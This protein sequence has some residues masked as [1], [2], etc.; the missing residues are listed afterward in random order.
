MEEKLIKRDYLFHQYNPVENS[1][2][3][4]APITWRGIVQHLTD[5]RQVDIAT[6]GNA[7]VADDPNTGNIDE[8]KQALADGT[9]VLMPQFTVNGR[10]IGNSVLIYGLSALLRLNVIRAIASDATTPFFKD[11][12]KFKYGFYTWRKITA[13]GYLDNNDTPRCTQLIQWKPFG[14]S[15]QLD[16][17]LAG[18]N[19]NGQILATQNLNMLLNSEKVRCLAKGECVIPISSLVGADNV[20]TKRIYKELSTPIEIMYEPLSQDGSHIL[21]QKIYFAIQSDMDLQTAARLR[22]L[23]QVVTKLYY[24]SKV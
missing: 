17:L 15:H 4:F 6:I 12:V 1:F 24:T 11:M 14:Y 7:A 3:G 5:I 18:A 23:A 20:R 21:N 2:V 16:N 9:N 19:N 22:P 13:T 10:R 8:E